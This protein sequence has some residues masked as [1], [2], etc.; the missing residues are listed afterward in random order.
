MLNS[1]KVSKIEKTFTD[2]KTNEVKKICIDYAKV[3]DRLEAFRTNHPNSK[4]LTSYKNENNK[5]VFKA[6]LWRDKTEVIQS[7]AN[8]ISKE[9]IYLTADAEA[10][11]QK[12]ITND[13]DFEKLETMAIGR[14]LSNLGYSSTGNI[15]EHKT[16]GLDK[17]K[18]EL[19]QKA[20]DDVISDLQSCKTLAKL[21][22]TYQALNPVLRTDKAIKV[23]TEEIK[24]RLGTEFTNIKDKQIDYPDWWNVK[25]NTTINQGIE[26]NE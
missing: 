14:A 11:A 19:Y 10:T 7:L 8:G 3:T 5:V 22:E 17:Y 12:T 13:K 21:K 20:V 18:D 1:V 15:A 16:N 23:I 6:F 2:K 4:I 26:K 24:K 25:N 9:L